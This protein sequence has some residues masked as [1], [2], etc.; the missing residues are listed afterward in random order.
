MINNDNT[1]WQTYLSLMDKSPY[2]SDESLKE[3][4]RKDE[5]L[6]APMVRDILVANPQAAK[7][8]KFQLYLMSD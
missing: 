4:A 8:Q 7:M 1:A 3:V 6:T 5:G 2:L